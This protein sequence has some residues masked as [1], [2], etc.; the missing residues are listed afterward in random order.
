PRSGARSGDRGRWPSGRTRRRTRR[1]RSSSGPRYGP[2]AACGTWFA[3]VATSPLP[4][5]TCRTGGT[6]A[7]ATLA[8]RAAGFFLLL[9]SNLGEVED[10]ALV[11][12]YLDA[13]HAVG[14]VSLG[15]AVVDVRAQGMQ[16]HAAFAVPLR[17]G[18]LGAVQAAGDVDLDAQGAEAH[19]VADRALHGA[20]EHDAALQLLGDGLG[21]QLGV[22]LGL[23][24]LADVDVRRDAHQLADLAAQLL[25][26]LTALADHHARAGGVDG[27][28]GGLG[29]ALDQDAADAGLGQLLAQHLADLQVGRQ[30]VGVLALARVPLRVPVLGDAQADAGGMNFVTH[31]TCPLPRRR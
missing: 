1:W 11:D 2:C 19:R 22:E 3:W 23:A 24:H 9:L 7:V 27:D 13:D 4:R 25:D 12:P 18:D 29:R 8:A 26:V 5:F 31:I 20:A 17:T 16:R 10:L 30:V 21:D 15:K 28:A 6:L 14:G